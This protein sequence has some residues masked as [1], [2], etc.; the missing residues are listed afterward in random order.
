MYT[1]PNSSVAYF[2]A[3]AIV[4]ILVPIIISLVYVKVKKEKITTV[5]IG[6]LTFFLFAIVLESIPKAVLMQIPSPVSRFV[7]GNPWVLI[8]TGALLAGI[9]EETGRLVAFKFM[10]KNR[11][12]RTTATA[13]GIGHGLFEVM[14]ILGYS[15][16]QYLSYISLIKAGT[17]ETVINQVAMVSPDQ[18][19][20]LSALPAQIA[21]VTWLNFVLAIVERTSAVLFHIGASFIVFYAVKT[22]KKGI[23]YLVA[24][25]L[26]AALDTFAGLLTVGVISNIFVLE[27]LL[28]VFSIAVFCLGYFKFFKQVKA[29]EVETE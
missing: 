6:A 20:A 10:L 14:F 26:H 15:A 13:Y 24:V 21:A 9:F 3:M 16:I 17:F 23:F 22:P 28:M 29:V 4:G 19:A 11:N 5:L 7:M 2:V 27:A 18:A 12:E 8:I 1:I 25:L